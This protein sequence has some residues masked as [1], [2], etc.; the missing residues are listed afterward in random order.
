M[1]NITVK[2]SLSEEEWEVLLERAKKS[3]PAI[4]AEMQELGYDY[5]LEEAIDTEIKVIVSS[6]IESY[7][8]YDKVRHNVSVKEAIQKAIQD[9]MRGKNGEEQKL[10]Q[11]KKR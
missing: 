1:K 6:D 8:I 4:K 11:S 5:S 9:E 7:D 3:Y 2:F 10:E